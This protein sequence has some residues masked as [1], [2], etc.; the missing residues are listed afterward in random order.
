M[1]AS[2]VSSIDAA[3][4]LLARRRARQSFAGFCRYVAPDEPPAKHHQI[5]CDIGDDIVEGRCKR[6]IFLM[7]PGSAKSTYAT[8]RFPAFYLGRLKKKGVICASYNDTLAT[9]FGKK[10][11]NLI[12]QSE[13]QT[14]FPGLAL[15]AD[16][17]AKGEW[18]TEEGGFY[19]A[20]GIGG[21][22]TGRRADL[23]IID[24]PI[25]GRKDADSE[26][27]RDN[28]WN[29]YVDDFRTRLKPEAAIIIILT[30][31]HQDDLVGRILPEDWDGE[32][33]TVTARDGEQWRVV[34][35][36]AEARQND[37]LGRSEGE[38]LWPEWFSY[39]WWQQ[40]KT[41][42]TQQGYRSWNSLYQQTPTD[43]EGTFFRREWFKRFDLKD[44]PKTTN[45]QSSD[46]ATKEDEGDYTELGVFGIDQDN[47]V[48]VKD[49]W[50][51]QATTDVWIDAQLDQ[52][53]GFSCFATFGETGQI[54]RAVEP[55]Q[56]MRARQ[57]KVYPR[58]EWLVRTGDKAAMARS[59]Q[60]MAS[61]G[62]VHIPNTEWGE[63]LIN[64]LCNFPNGKYDDAVDVCALMAM[65][66]Q[67][68][69]PAIVGGETKKPKGDTDAWGRARRGSDSWRT[70]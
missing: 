23:G 49:W 33:G 12:R 24:D 64:Q 32:S 1:Q 48:W 63:R 60:G 7:P 56:T 25:R 59:F 38:W 20:V 5:I 13:T 50:Y 57:R 35:L 40:T 17:Q 69:H 61:S 19:F 43:D 47:E 53:K 18:E 42:V 70:M 45:Y 2:N 8:V 30:R 21:G 31:W 39:E 28:C 46:F 22:V 29:W 52:Y 51:K 41:T 55:F 6:A 11:R 34:C 16:S 37:I 44:C 3:R 66:I 58:F 54:R 67:M 9:Q 36:P 26:L 4:E 62:M 15:T 10:T 68:A 65:A 27:V 14:V